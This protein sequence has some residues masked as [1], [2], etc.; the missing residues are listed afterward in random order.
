MRLT[1]LL[2]FIAAALVLAAIL[3]PVFTSCGPPAAQTRCLSNVK[4]QVLGLIVYGTDHDVRFPA[5]DGWMDA[6][7]PYTKNKA[8]FHDPEGV[9]KD[10]YGYAFNAALSFAKPP[11]AP[12]GVPLVYDSANPIRN[13]SDRMASLPARGRHPA[14]EPRTNTIGYADGHAKGVKP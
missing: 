13:A 12:E 2:A 14:R 11:K 9:P 1:H 8:I 3:F 6:L 5:R 7:G 4:Q 10:A